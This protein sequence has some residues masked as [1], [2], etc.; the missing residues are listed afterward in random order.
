MTKGGASSCHLTK[1]DSDI[2]SCFGTTKVKQ[3]SNF[4]DA[5]QAGNEAY[6]G[7]DFFKVGDR[8]GIGIY[9]LI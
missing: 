9:R 8:K 6:K 4:S 7:A 1:S 2:S 5:S 3:M